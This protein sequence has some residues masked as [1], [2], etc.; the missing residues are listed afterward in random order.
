MK[1]RNEKME[2]KVTLYSVSEEAVEFIRTYIL[3]VKHID[4]IDE[5]VLYDIFDIAES[6]E[7]DMI[8]E[9]GFDREDNP[10]MERDTMGMNF[11]SE[12][13]GQDGEPDLEDLNRRL[14]LRKTN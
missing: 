8:D 5:D 14:G 12:I 7:L 10:F 4:F 6:W 1:K 9:N 11:V 2:Q 3:P 13:S